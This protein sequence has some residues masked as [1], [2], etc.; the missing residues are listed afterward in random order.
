MFGRLVRA[1]RLRARVKES[2]SPGTDRP[3][4]RFRDR[5]IIFDRHGDVAQL[6]RANG[7]YPLGP[8]FESA[9]RY[10]F[11]HPDLG[12]PQPTQ[13]RRL[14]CG[15][16]PPSRHVLIGGDA[17]H[18]ESI[19]CTKRNTPIALIPRRFHLTAGFFC[20]RLSGRAG[21]GP[22]SSSKESSRA[23]A[24]KR[25]MPLATRSLILDILLSSSTCSAM[26]HCRNWK[27]VVSPS[28][29]AA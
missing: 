16:P 23:S 11:F 1:V 14:N 25:L 26:N 10:H 24:W 3:S 15:N 18:R 5:S 29:I 28:A 9:R 27:A 19:I 2:G 20:V 4:D 21:R 8:R 17:F 22:H 7:S 13:A 6:V 12:S